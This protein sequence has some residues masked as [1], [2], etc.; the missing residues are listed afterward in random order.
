[1]HIVVVPTVPAVYNF[2]AKQLY[3]TY[4]Y[5]NCL[6]NPVNRQNQ[7]KLRQSTSVGFHMSQLIA[8]SINIVLNKSQIHQFYFDN[9]HIQAKQYT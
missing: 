4:N 6:M 7:K 3:N 2:T 8:E 9:W 1:M 5:S